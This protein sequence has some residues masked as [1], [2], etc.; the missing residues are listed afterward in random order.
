MATRR[1]LTKQYIVVQRAD[2]HSERSLYRLV[3]ADCHRRHPADQ[4]AAQRTTT[5]AE[6]AKPSGLA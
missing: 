6:P 5:P 3:H 4:A 1:A 2:G